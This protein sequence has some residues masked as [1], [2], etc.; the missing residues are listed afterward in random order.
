[1]YGSGVTE[2]FDQGVVFTPERAA[3]RKADLTTKEEESPLKVATCSSDEAQGW[4]LQ[5]DT[6]NAGLVWPP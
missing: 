1:M 2:W 5:L 6:A 3:R 4:R